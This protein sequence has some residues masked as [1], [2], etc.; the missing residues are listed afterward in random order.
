MVAAYGLTDRALRHILGSCLRYWL[1]PK[2]RNHV[3]AT[4]A[5]RNQVVEL[6]LV[7]KVIREVVK[8]ENVPSLFEVLRLVDHKEPGRMPPGA[9]FVTISRDHCARRKLWVGDLVGIGRAGQ[10][11]ESERPA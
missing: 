5:P 11:S 7:A 8:P 6:V 9:R 10:Q 3:R 2:V 4:N 1:R